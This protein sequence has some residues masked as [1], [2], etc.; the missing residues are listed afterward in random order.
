M[1]HLAVAELVQSMNKGMPGPK[2]FAHPVHQA[3]GNALFEGSFSHTELQRFHLP[4]SVAHDVVITAASFGFIEARDPSAPYRKDFQ[5]LAQT[6]A[7]NT[8]APIVTQI[9][10]GRERFEAALFS[11]T[12]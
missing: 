2:R 12:V 8:N 7:T 11:P 9:N 4:K 6:I 3:F 5:E 10:G 1:N